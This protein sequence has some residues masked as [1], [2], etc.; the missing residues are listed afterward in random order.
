MTLQTPQ[1]H[2]RTGTLRRSIQMDYPHRIIHNFRY[3]FRSIRMNCHPS[4]ILRVLARVGILPR[5]L[6]LSVRGFG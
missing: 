5:I 2:T 6:V 4:F 3:R 1:S